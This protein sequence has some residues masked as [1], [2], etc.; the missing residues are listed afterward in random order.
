MMLCPRKSSDSLFR[1][2]FTLDLMSSSSSHTR[3]LIRSEELWHSLTKQNKTKKGAKKK[4]KL[5]NIKLQ[6]DRYYKGVIKVSTY[7]T[8]DNKHSRNRKTKQNTTTPPN[9][10]F[11]FITKKRL[12]NG[13]FPPRLD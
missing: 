3:T 2:C 4:H 8:T 13:T 5:N 6:D 11:D 1:R 10:F 7:S 12:T 9:N